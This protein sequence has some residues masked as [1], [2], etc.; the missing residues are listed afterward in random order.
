MSVSFLKQKKSLLIPLKSP[1]IYPAAGVM[2][3]LS[4][5]LSSKMSAC[6]SPPSHTQDSV[7][8]EGAELSVVG[9]AG[10][11]R[12]AHIA[13]VKLIYRRDDH[14]RLQFGLNP[15]GLCLFSKSGRRR[16]FN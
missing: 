12:E 1:T 5:K 7:S 11:G 10:R 14:T 8:H 13:A 6:T 9:G 2:F 15:S 3:L 4:V 16:T